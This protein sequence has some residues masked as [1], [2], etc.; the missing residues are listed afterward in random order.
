VLGILLFLSKSFYLISIANP[1]VRWN[2]AYFASHAQVLGIFLSNIFANGG[3]VW[4]N[5]SYGQT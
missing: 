1:G 4:H 3:I 5:L 2:N